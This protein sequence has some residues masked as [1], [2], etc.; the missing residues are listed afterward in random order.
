MATEVGTAYVA[1]IP[2]AKGFASK[3]Q[4][5][6]SGEVAQA[7]KT[8][9]DQYGGGFIKS[10][11][12]KL[13]GSNAK[14]LFAGVA[15]A[16]VA[17][18]GVA[19]KGLYELGETF[20]ELEDTIITGTGASG[21]ALDSLNKS[22]ENIAKTT[23][24]GFGDIGTAVAD[25]NTRLGLTGKPLEKMSEQM[26]NVSRL[27]GTDLSTNISTV[28]RVMG[29]WGVKTEDQSKVLDQLFYTS[30]ATGIGMDKL[31]QNVVSFGAPLR[32][33]GFSMEE[34]LALFGKWEKEGVNTNVIFAGLKAGLGKIS[35]AGKEP[36]KELARV[37][38]AI[39]GAANAGEANQIAI[40]TFGTRAGP[41]LA[42]AVREGRFELGDLV[43]GIKGSEGT[44]AKTDKSTRDFAES[45]QIFKNQVLVKLRPLAEA[46]FSAFVEGANKL[47]PKLIQVGG[48]VADRVVPVL[49]KLPPIALK[50]FSAAQS[51][52]GF[53]AKH[54]TTLKVL[55]G[56]LAGLVVVT[57][58]HAAVVAIQGG[59][60]KRMIVQSKIAQAATKA[61][62]AVQWILNAALSANPLALIVIG[63]AGL[64][65][66]LVLAWKKSETFRAIVTGVFNKVKAVVSAVW[67]GIK[68]G[69][70][71]LVGF[72]TKLPGRIWNGIKGIGKAVGG[73]F[74]GAM[75]TS[76]N[77]VSKGLGAVVRF[78]VQ[79]PQRIWNGIKT[80]AAKVRAAFN[81]A[82]KVAKTLVSN[83]IDNNVRLWSNLPRR[84][85]NALRNLAKN[86]RDTFAKAFDRVDQVIANGRD[87][88]IGAVRAIPGKLLAL[89]SKFLNAGRTI[90]G[91]FFDGLA[92]LGSIG[93]NVASKLMN[94]IIGPINSAIRAIND[95]I[96]NKIGIGKVSI[97]LPNNP[98][99]TIPKLATGARVTGTT[100]AYIGEGRE[101]E[102]VL[103]DSML[104]GLLER[105][106]AA[107]AAGTTGH[108]TITN[109][110][111]GT[112][113]F[114]LVAEESL[115]SEARF[116][117]HV[118]AMHA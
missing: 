81:A 5:E 103:P 9:G 96:P 75:K 22:A 64:V 59:A 110:R 78:H 76:K 108:L 118:G 58:L 87:K 72:F 29:D 80:I 52:F 69:A 7:G 56:V 94:G 47:L 34:S 18:A 62:A 95:A 107:G 90:I 28:S 51:V 11:M 46:T 23:P 31:A 66:A 82:M 36:A 42:A 4:A 115:A 71:A 93:S 48:E 45:W 57:K 102:T 12:A 100:L 83:G 97:N 49:S 8:G 38:E 33:F 32:Q 61:W 21:A 63:I 99:P 1:L 14:K 3:M 73:V 35:K 39:K 114:R 10:G 86:L 77:V 54:T 98:F 13:G 116:R 44:I 92:K 60:I 105:A 85:V 89:G 74:S 53:L 26:L 40:E 109:W 24:S 91:N 70:D 84:I 55:A 43:K 117:Q 104:S 20:D 68:A 30:Q 79:L 15:V 6:L 27:T 113:Y 67:D 111:D 88:V 106:N 41:D 16:G 112:G 2:S 19:A 101:P 65:A 17:A 50:L 37:Q 25:L